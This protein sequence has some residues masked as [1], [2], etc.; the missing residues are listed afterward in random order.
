MDLFGSTPQPR[1]TAATTRKATRAHDKIIDRIAQ[2]V[3]AY[4]KGRGQL[5]PRIVVNWGQ[6]EVLSSC[7]T[8]S[9][10]GIPIVR[11]EI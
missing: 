6:H 3:S 11:E 5:P 2:Y 1:A 9:Y 10:R 8:T 4:E 7:G